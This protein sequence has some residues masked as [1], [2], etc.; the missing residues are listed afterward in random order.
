MIHRPDRLA[1]IFSAFEKYKLEPK[2]LQLIFPF[3]DASPTMVLIEGR[4]NANPELKVLPPLIVYKSKGEYTETVKN[5][6]DQS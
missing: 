6:Y 3:I 1:E 5:I 4:K 2:K